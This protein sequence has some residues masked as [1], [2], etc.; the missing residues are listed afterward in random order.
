MICNLYVLFFCDGIGY[1]SDVSIVEFR[2]VIQV[3]V[4]FTLLI[5]KHTDGQDSLFLQRMF[6]GIHAFHLQPK[7]ERCLWIDGLKLAVSI[8]DAHP[9]K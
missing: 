2:G 5:P 7:L 1:C 6:K 3:G 4:Q 9:K 8:K